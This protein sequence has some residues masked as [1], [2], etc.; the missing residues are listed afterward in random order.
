MTLPASQLNKVQRVLNT[1][2]RLVCCALRLSYITPLMYELHWLPLK[3]R[4][5]FKI[6]LFAFKAYPW[7]SR[8]IHSELSFFEIARCI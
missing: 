4:I 1:T 2:A 7:Y 3:R 6:L 8:Y 5:H